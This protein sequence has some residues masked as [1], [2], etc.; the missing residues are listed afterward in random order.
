MPPTPKPPKRQPPPQTRNGCKV[1]PT[2]TTT[3]TTTAKRQISNSSKSRGKA[4]ESPQSTPKPPQRSTTRTQAQ[5]ARSPGRSGLGSQV[6]GGSPGRVNH[7]PVHVTGSVRLRSRGNPL[8]QHGVGEDPP[9]R[10]MS[11]RGMGCSKK[12]PPLTVKPSRGGKKARGRGARGA[13]GQRWS[14]RGIEQGPEESDP[15][16]IDPSVIDQEKEVVSHDREGQPLNLR[17]ELDDPSCVD[18]QEPGVGHDGKGKL[19]NLRTD[20]SASDDKHEELVAHNGDAV[21]TNPHN[22]PFSH[23]GEVNNS[24]LNDPISVDQQQEKL[25]NN[26]S[27]GNSVQFYQSHELGDSTSDE[28]QEVSVVPKGEDKAKINLGA[29]QIEMEQ[30]ERDTHAE[31]GR[32][33]ERLEKDGK[34][35]VEKE[36]EE[37][38]EEGEKTDEEKKKAEEEERVEIVKVKETKE[39]EEKDE[40]LEKREVISRPPDT[41]S[42]MSVSQHQKPP[43]QDDV[44]MMQSPVHPPSVSEPATSDLVSPPLSHPH[45][46]FPLQPAMSH[47]I[48]V[49]NQGAKLIQPTQT[50]EIHK[51]LKVPTTFHETSQMT[52]VHPVSLSLSVAF[53]SEPHKSLCVIPANPAL[54]QSLE[55]PVSPEARQL[56][57]PVDEETKESS[58]HLNAKL[59]SSSASSSS[60]LYTSA[61][62]PITV[63]VPDLGPLSN[64]HNNYPEEPPSSSSLPYTKKDVFTTGSEPDKDI[65]SVSDCDLGSG[66]MTHNKYNQDEPQP[67]LPNT[68][69]RSE[70]NTDIASVSD[71]GSVPKTSSI[72]NQ[73]SSSSKF[74]FSFS[75]S[76][77]STQS[78]YS[79]DTE[80]ETGYGEPSPP[81]HPSLDLGHLDGGTSLP[82]TPRIIQ[83]RERKKRSRCGGCEPCLRKINCG[84]CSCCLNRRTG[85]QICKLRK[86]M[87]LRKRRPMSLLTLTSTQVG[88]GSVAKPALKKQFPR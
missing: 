37:A 2:T 32:G 46:T 64:N 16:S 1:I 47:D 25:V 55:S 13:R 69:T 24:E 3:T 53:L 76:S 45:P 36:G 28:R 54:S 6:P 40:R 88:A 50:V 39:R 66:P 62:V 5:P 10:R 21:G 61:E 60:D 57:R 77:E 70:P 11:L 58:N 31:E 20:D 4:F 22:K 81:G 52:S 68:D 26:I 85:H 44:L 30:R 27:E 29:E 9:G 87:E 12:F 34:E 82:R 41:S 73:E 84:Q 43:L 35:A 49:F 78:S 33:G 59:S 8:L 42:S 72:P 38:M 75:C 19:L 17:T 79:F 71:L 74:S 63:S 48:K 83:R 7:A 86:C 14:E 51:P 15:G 65:V 80:S 56:L 67:S 18:Q 23:S